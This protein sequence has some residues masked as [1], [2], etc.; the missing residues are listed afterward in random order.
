MIVMEEIANRIGQFDQHLMSNRR[1]RTLDTLYSISCL[2]HDLL[3]LRILFNPL[4][5]ILNR[6]QR[7]TT[8]DQS[9]VYR[10]TDPSI[11]L[12]LKHKVI[13]RAAIPKRLQTNRNHQHLDLRSIYLNDYIYVYFNDLN[14][15]IKAV[16]DSL[17]IQ[18]EN[19]SI[20][21]S[22]WITLNSNEVQEILNFLMLISVLVM[23]CNLLTGMHATNFQIQPQYQYFYGY[24]IVLSCLF[25][26]LIGMI[27]WYKIKRWF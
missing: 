2:Q 1:S 16:I 18:R 9:I 12:G 25:V 19:V 22:F 7:G 27:G 8:D 26:I 11:R 24:Y 5:E 10:R 20:L 23:P 15:H 13:R 6:L 4:K 21:I 17:E 14:N 3:H